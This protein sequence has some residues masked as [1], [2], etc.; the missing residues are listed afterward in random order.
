ME[1]KPNVFA[2][3]EEFDEGEESHQSDTDGSD[4][5][6]GAPAAEPPLSH[7]ATLASPPTTPEMSKR[8]P[9]M[10]IIHHTSSVHS[11]SGISIGSDTPEQESPLIQR[12]AGEARTFPAQTRQMTRQSSNSSSTSHKRTSRSRQPDN[13]DASPESFYTR[14][15]RSRG[16]S[17]IRM[18]PFPPMQ[19]L[20]PF[21]QPQS[22]V[23]HCSENQGPD[24]SQLSRH[25]SAVEADE[26]SAPPIYRRFETLTNRL[27]LQLQAE[28]QTL[29]TDLADLDS[30]ILATEK[31]NSRSR[32][33][34]HSK[35]SWQRADLCALLSVKLDTYRT[36]SP[37]GP[38]FTLLRRSP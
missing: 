27:L 31:S 1:A 26:S 3:M 20:V 24:F 4:M 29:E 15:V 32:N 38:D 6:D 14:P 34:R 12:K 28:I 7:A 25:L 17:N 10:P 23:E 35:L 22:E 11:D 30:A 33:A 13:F 2:F 8:Q 16:P 5:E 37:Y 19:T 9:I 21:Q 36:F 18:T